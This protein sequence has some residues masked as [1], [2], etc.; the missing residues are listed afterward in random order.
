MRLASRTA[1]RL[2][3]HFDQSTL[4]RGLL[5]SCLFLSNLIYANPAPFLMAATGGTD[6]AEPYDCQLFHKTALDMNP[7]FSA[8][9]V[10]EYHQK[11]LD[12]AR[13]RHAP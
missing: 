13:H 9:F 3:Q 2:N 7:I 11:L 10:R 5:T 12:Q 1:L 4:S 6:Q 8:A